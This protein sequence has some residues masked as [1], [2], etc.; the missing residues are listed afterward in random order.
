MKREKI[1]ISDNGVV[2]MPSAASI[3]N[4]QSLPT[5]QILMADFEIAELFGVL[6][7]TVRSNI[8]TI[9]KTGI[10]TAD[11]TNGATLVGNNLLP[12][13]YGL[14]MITA[15]AFRIH[16]RQAQVFRKMVLSRLST[17]NKSTSLSLVVQVDGGKRLNRV[18]N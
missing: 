4:E 18:A 15:L 14:D 7:P 2:S 5:A 6:I 8:R 17:V 11:L 9:L 3:S 12:D 10:V 16:S 1:T 13:Y